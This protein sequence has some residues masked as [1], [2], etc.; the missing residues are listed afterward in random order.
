MALEGPGAR[1]RPSVTLRLR[2]VRALRVRAL[3]VSS[4]TTRAV[5]VRLAPPLAL[6]DC[7]TAHGRVRWHHASAISSTSYACVRRHH[8]LLLPGPWSLTPDPCPLVPG[9]HHHLL[10]RRALRRV[11]RE[12]LALRFEPAWRWLLAST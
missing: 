12:E 3:R 4:H 5:R 6:E 10:L 1:A 9:R 11:L 7:W 2:M 8:L